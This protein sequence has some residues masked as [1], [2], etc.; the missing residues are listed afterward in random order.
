MV[1]D[2]LD[3]AFHIC[4]GYAQMFSFFVPI[5]S[6][7]LSDWY[8]FIDIFLMNGAVS[9]ILFIVPVRREILLCDLLYIIYKG[10]SPYIWA[11][12]VCLLFDDR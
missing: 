2:H 3:H 5:F 10:V 9:F 11:L 7:S 8:I 4:V 6:L 12:F 1:C